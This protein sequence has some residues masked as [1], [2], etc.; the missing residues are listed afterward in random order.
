[1]TTFAVEWPWSQAEQALAGWSAWAPDAADA[2]STVLSVATGAVGPRVVASGQLLGGSDSLAPLLAPLAAV[3]T[4]TRVATLERSFIDAMLM[5]ASCSHGIA[6]CH[7]PPRGTVPRGMFA[8]KSDY[9]SKPLSSE[10][11]NVVLGAIEA[12]Q[13]AGASGTV[14]F[15]AYGGA[16]N[17]VPTGATAFVHRDVLCSVQ[18]IATSDAPA[19]VTEAQD[20]LVGLHTGLQPHVSGGAYVNYVDPDL[21]NWARAYYGSNYP[22]LR[23]VKRRYDAAEVFRFPQSIRP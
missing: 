15:D 23:Q 10:G 11:A 22:R 18:E 17:R 1:V 5:W 6:D 21:A 2:I 20:W 14:L 16:I 13:S 3:G 4:P 9:L 19:G 8:A 12:R 7:L